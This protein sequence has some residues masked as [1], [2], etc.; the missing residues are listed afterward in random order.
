MMKTLFLAESVSTVAHTHSRIRDLNKPPTLNITFQ[1]YIKCFLMLNVNMLN[2]LYYF[3]L[4]EGISKILNG[5]VGSLQ[6][7]ECNIDFNWPHPTGS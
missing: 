2:V 4:V 7:H 6:F 3:C 1:H 5:R